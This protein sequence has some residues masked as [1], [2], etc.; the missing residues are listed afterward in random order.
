MSGWRNGLELRDRGPSIGDHSYSESEGNS[1]EWDP[2]MDSR[3]V[4]SDLRQVY[5]R[6][7]MSQGE[8]SVIKPGNIQRKSS[9]SP[10]SDES[11]GSVPISMALPKWLVGSR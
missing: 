7:E 2:P 1:A 10:D 4:E 3:G 5:G 9:I 6:P 8:E 11:S